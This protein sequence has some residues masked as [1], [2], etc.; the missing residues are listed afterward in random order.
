[1]FNMNTTNQFLVVQMNF[2]KEA[3]DGKKIIEDVHYE[4]SY[5]EISEE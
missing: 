1:M 3:H 2:T 5:Y 4:Y